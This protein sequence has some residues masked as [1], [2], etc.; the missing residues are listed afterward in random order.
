VANKYYSNH[1]VASSQEAGIFAD[2]LTWT[3]FDILREAGA[4]G[5]TARDVYEKVE[6]KLRK[7]VSPKKV[8]ALLRRYYQEEWTHKYYDKDVL[9]Q[10]NVINLQWGTVEFD[11]D[12]EDRILEKEKDYIKKYLFTHFKEYLAKTL[13]DLNEDESGKKWVPLAV[14]K[15]RNIL[16][17]KQDRSFPGDVLCR[18]CDISHEADEFFCSLLD[19]ATSEFLDSK[20]YDEFLKQ[21]GYMYEEQ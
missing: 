12:Y 16:K 18:E 15:R 21:H 17:D 9:A 14:K 8:Y 1:S 6:K 5:L 10:R 4:K 20:E 7:P 3:I 13:E 19:L 2:E 11:E